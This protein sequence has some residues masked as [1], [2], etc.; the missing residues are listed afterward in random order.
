MTHAPAPDEAEYYSHVRT[1]ILPLLSGPYAQVLELGCGRGHTL[2]HLKQKGLAG[3]TVGCELS[4][5]AGEAARSRVDEVVVTDLEDQAPLFPDGRFDLL[6][7]LDVLEHLRDPWLQL[8]RFC[9]WVRPGGVV[10]GSLPNVRYFAVVWDLLVRARWE[11]V[12]AG[13]LDRTHLRFFTRRSTIALFDQAR[14]A[15]E[16]ILPALHRRREIWLNKLTFGGLEGLLAQQYL[17]RGRKA[18]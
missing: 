6:L 7:C 15:V 16:Q 2:A 5:E 17:I 9:R 13:I 18:T 10:I 8:Q 11:Y 1:D 12:D 4:A 14:L 3:R